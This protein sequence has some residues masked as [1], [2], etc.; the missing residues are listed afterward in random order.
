MFPSTSI[1]RKFS[2]FRLL[3]HNVCKYYTISNDGADVKPSRYTNHEPIILFTLYIYSLYTH[4]LL[5]SNKLNAACVMGRV[6]VS[7]LSR[8]TAHRVSAH[9]ALRRRGTTRLF[10]YMDFDRYLYPSRAI[11]ICRRNS[12]D[13]LPRSYIYTY[14]RVFS[15]FRRSS[16]QLSRRLCASHLPHR[17]IFRERER[18]RERTFWLFRRAVCGGNVLTSKSACGEREER[19]GRQRERATNMCARRDG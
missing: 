4:R 11:Y 8:S 6:N 10:V 1:Y 12:A 19:D 15:S 7:S 2:N 3:F 13:S 14:S 17:T 9:V 5:F 18:Q 16:R